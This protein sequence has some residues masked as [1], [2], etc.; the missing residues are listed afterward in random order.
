MGFISH[1]NFGDFFGLLFCFF[2][3]ILGH[4]TYWQLKNI[5]VITVVLQNRPEG[6]LT[7]RPEE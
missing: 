5:P 6:C 1:S 7:T 2:L 3:A 4:F